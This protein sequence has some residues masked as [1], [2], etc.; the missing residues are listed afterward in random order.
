LE[1]AV[2]SGAIERVREAEDD[3]RSEAGRAQQYLRARCA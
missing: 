2:R 3:L 1:E